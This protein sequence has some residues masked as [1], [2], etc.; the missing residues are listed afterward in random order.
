LKEKDFNFEKFRR[1]AIFSG[2][3]YLESIPGIGLGKAKKLFMNDSEE[4]LVKVSSE[5]Y[6]IRIKLS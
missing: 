5:K 2:C 1:M 4:D 6:L 3:D